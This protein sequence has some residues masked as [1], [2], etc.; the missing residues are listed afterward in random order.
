MS[1]VHPIRSSTAAS[2]RARAGRD[3]HDVRHDVGVID[4]M[5]P[6]Q[7]L[8]TEAPIAISVIDPDGTQ[9]VC[10]QAYADMLGYSME[11]VRTLDVGAVTRADDRIWT[12]AYLDRLVSGELEHYVTDKVYVRRDGSTFAGRLTTRAL[13]DQHGRCTHLIGA[14]VPIETRPRIGSAQVRRMLG[15]T[16]DT[17][18]LVDE[19]GAVIETTGRYAPVLGY[20]SEFWETRT[21]F[22]LVERDDV[23]RILTIREDLIADPGGEIETEIVV[24]SAG[25][26]D[27]ILHVRAFNALDDPDLHALV[28]VT[29]NVTEHRRAVAELARAKRRAEAHVDSQTRLLAT[30]SHELRNPLH[31][32]HGLADLLADDQLPEHTAELVRTLRRQL[33]SLT[34]VTDDLLDAA[35]LDG[36]RIAMQPVATELAEIVTDVVQLARASV[37]TRG[38]EAALDVS[39]RFVQGVPAWVSADADRLRQVLSNLVGNAVKFT[40]TGSIQVVVRADAGD[41]VFSVVDTGIGIPADEHE[42]VLQPFGVGSTAGDRRGAG[43][44]LAVVQRIVHAMGGTLTMTSAPGTGTRFDVRVPLEAVEPPVRAAAAEI[45]AGTRVLVVEDN[46]VNQQLAE[47]QLQRLGLVPTIVGS[48]EEAIA[49]LS[50]PTTEAFSVILM[51]HQLPGMSGTDTT[52][53]IRRLAGPVA[54][55]PVIGVSA[56]ASASSRDEFTDAGMDAFIAKPASLGDLS[57]AIGDVLAGRAV[58]GAPGSASGVSEHEAAP[59]A[60]PPCIDVAVL[61]RLAGELGG[62]EVV[63]SLIVTYC[64][65]LDHRI[66][67]ILDPQAHG[68]TDA[69]AVAHTLKSSSRL[70]GALELGEVCASIERTGEPGG[71]DLRALADRSRHE[72]T[73]WA[74][75]RLGS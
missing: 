56:S 15:Y 74:E 12:R 59:A 13:R 6:W 11:E 46:P 28:V 2:G 8:V 63:A 33:K 45:G 65:E 23:D 41:V 70:L 32:A 36:G 67:S 16:N 34:Q 22:D 27:Q 9:V 14:I 10:N 48:G 35:R 17:L 39:S 4:D 66:A 42:T 18:T 21:V 31:A 60:V 73:R 58:V 72:L 61:D 44:G 20:P 30:V 49:L 71:P 26:D 24:K 25:G 75:E 69:S 53:A 37:I 57:A 47:R 29:R 55:I 51:D 1:A 40:D 19:H 5:V 54:A 64:G 62:P 50:D 68:H 52:R 3:R 38:K 43:L 7:R